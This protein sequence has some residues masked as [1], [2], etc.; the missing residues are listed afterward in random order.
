V[1]GKIKRRLARTLIHLSKRLGEPAEDGSVH[2]I[3]M[4]HQLLSQHIGTSRE[5]VTSHMNRFRKKGYLDY[6]RRQIV[7]YPRAFANWTNAASTPS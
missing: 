6:T 1:I 4:T 2:I 5:L 3:P 7:L